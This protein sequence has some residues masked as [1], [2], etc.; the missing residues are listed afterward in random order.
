MRM[1]QDCGGGKYNTPTAKGLERI[2]NV[3]IAFIKKF[4]AAVP[5]SYQA[6]TEKPKL[7]PDSQLLPDPVR[8]K[9]SQGD[10]AGPANDGHPRQPHAD[11]E[12]LVVR[13]VEEPGI[14]GPGISG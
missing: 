2:W 11:V 1:I 6:T 10:A 9:A 13:L 12:I 5:T 4:I 7:R 8:G 3:I 14:V